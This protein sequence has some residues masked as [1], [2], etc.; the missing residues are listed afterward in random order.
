MLH[1]YYSSVTLVLQRCYN[2]VALV[3]R[4]RYTGVTVVLH[5]RCC[6]A[7]ISIRRCFVPAFS[8][9]PQVVL[10][11]LIGILS[12]IIQGHPFL[13][14]TSQENEKKKAAERFLS[15]IQRKSVYRTRIAEL[16]ID[17]KL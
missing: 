11:S 13:K 9:I 17:E 5:W 2:V 4:W 7:A 6:V 1:W 15:Y 3:L 14:L 10:M 8:N 16:S 12:Q